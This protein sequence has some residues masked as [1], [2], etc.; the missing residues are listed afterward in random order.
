MKL[1]YISNTVMTALTVLALASC[2]DD[3][4]TLPSNPA[5]PTVGREV[6]SSVIYQVNPRFFASNGC[7]DAVTAEVGNIADMGVDV[8]WVMPVQEQG[9]KDAFGSP[10]CIKDYKSVNSRYGTVADFK[11]LVDTA[12]SKGMKVILDWVANHTSWDNNWI[13]EHPEY[14]VKDAN[15][16]IAQASTWSDVAQLDYS[17]AGTRAAMTDALAWWI[18]QTGIDGFRCDYA[19]GVPHDYWSEA[20][21]SLRA[22]HPELIMLAETSQKGFYND[23]FDMI[24]DWGFAPAMSDAFQGGRPADLFTKANSSWSDVPEGK[25]ILRYVF[26]H[27]FAA[28]NSFDRSFGSSEGIPAAYV[29]TAML[30]G[31]PMIYSSMEAED[32]ITGTLSFFNYRTL[33]W[34]ASKRAAFKAINS[35]F[36]AT[37]EVRRGQLATYADANVAVFTRSTPSQ[38]LLVMVNTTGKEQT[39]KT[40]ITLAGEQMT[41]L[42]G[43]GQ[44]TL[45]V[46]QTIAPYGYVILVK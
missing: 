7:L 12:H 9:V 45:P 25:Q 38:T 13:T 2:S 36:K 34:S 22:S 16:N 4:M 20:I 19:E 39:V 10:Y 40:P 42:I 30:H 46:T 23:G 32:N 14:Y 1:R 21:S 37:A 35:A 43:G 27:D 18:D 28:E 3:S 6:S 17:N 11:K 8:L 33:N 31:T 44:S 41:D 15:G 29:L 26:N 24:Y 5:A